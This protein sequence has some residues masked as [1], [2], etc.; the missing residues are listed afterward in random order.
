MAFHWQRQNRGYVQ[1]T[2]GNS[3]LII[4]QALDLGVSKASPDAHPAERVPRRVFISGFRDFARNP[5]MVLGAAVRT[6]LLAL[7]VT[8]GF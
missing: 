5:R 7:R 3:V 6:I 4:S 8:F 2:S 1:R